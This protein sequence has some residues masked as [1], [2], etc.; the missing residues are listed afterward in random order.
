MFKI[1]RRIT[2]FASDNVGAA[3]A[4]ANTRGLMIFH[5]MNG[6]IACAER[7]L[8]LDNTPCFYCAS[9]LDVHDK[10]Y[11]VADE[12]FFL[13][14]Y[15][16]IVDACNPDFVVLLD[17]PV[18]SLI[19][20]DISALAQELGE[21]TGL[22][23]IA[24]RSSLDKDYSNGLS[25]AYDAMLK[26]YGREMESIRKLRAGETELVGQLSTVENRRLGLLGLDLYD[27]AGIQNCQAILPFA[28]CVWG[29]AP[30]LESHKKMAE[31]DD[32]V[33]MST[34]AMKAAKNLKSKLGVNFM[35]LDECDEIRRIVPHIRDMR[36][37]LS[38]VLD[39][40]LPMPEPAHMP[41][42]MPWQQESKAQET[43]H[44]LIVGDQIVAHAAAKSVNEALAER[45]SPNAWP[46]ICEF[47]YALPFGLDKDIAFDTDYLVSS[48]D[49]LIDAVSCPEYDIV[50]GPSCLQKFVSHCQ[51]VVLENLAMRSE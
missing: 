40:I 7:F 14:Q 49:E 12:E 8:K 10:D 41:M 23:A 2:P 5:D 36:C 42:F 9:L 29:C 20:L 17:G 24:I 1:W 25:C 48:E 26:L 47:D 18:S 34:G 16:E 44:I 27:Y 19:G 28:H 33:V 31:V 21:R 6:S 22:V 11:V 39:Y 32:I 38:D 15:L 43:L 30:T 45:R 37:R 13:K 46:P 51:Y 35:T 4:F 50:I 3:S